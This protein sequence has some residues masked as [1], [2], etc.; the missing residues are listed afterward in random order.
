MVAL[1]IALSCQESVEELVRRLGTGD[2]EGRE[3]AVVELA[4][5]GEESRAA[6]ERVRG[7]A[8][9]AG[10]A[11][12]ALERIPLV[13]AVSAE[14]ETTFPGLRAKLAAGRA[15]ELPGILLSAPREVR[16]EALLPLARPAL[17]RAAGT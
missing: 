17:E 2:I 12:V 9:V 5:R 6:L 7:D 11:R 1:L 13:A 4:L 3:R 10:R 15:G 8:E 16:R 14:V